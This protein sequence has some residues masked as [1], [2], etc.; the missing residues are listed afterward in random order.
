MCG[1]CRWCAC[2]FSAHTS[3]MLRSADVLSDDRIVAHL[4]QIERPAL[5]S[6]LERDGAT[7]LGE[8]GARLWQYTPTCALEPAMHAA[9]AH[10]LARVEASPD[11]SA[12]AL[13]ALARRRVLQTTPHVTLTDGPIFLAAHHLGSRGLAADEPYVV[14]ACSGIGF[15]NNAWP[16]CLSYG[17]LALDDL[18]DLKAAAATRWRRADAD[19]RR[20]SQE[21]RISLV[22][23]HGR[24]LVFGAQISEE[25]VACCEAL[26]GHARALV[27]VPEAGTSFTAWAVRVSAALVTRVLR[28]RVITLDLGAVIARYLHTVLG[29]LAHPLARLLFH[30]PVRTRVLQCLPPVPLFLTVG[31]DEATVLEPLRAE[32]ASLRG[33]T[34]T[35]PLE[36]E[37]I[38]EALA[39]EQLCPGTFLTFTA[40]IAQ[41]GFACFGGVD[42]LEYLAQFRPAWAAAGEWPSSTAPL[43]LLTSGRMVDD[44]G[45]DLFPLDVIYGVPFAP[46]HGDTLMGFLRPQFARLLQRPFAWGVA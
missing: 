40:L 33:R 21:R 6:L 30:A 24:E 17:R 25:T 23:R 20:D 35:L 9:F 27:G 31:A 22:P 32:G 11:D 36:P 5:A 43:D 4:R 37:V 19:R 44:H 10:E 16:G 38:R 8:W 26:V 18:V 15:A 29:D 45:V 13:V 14:G 12:A 28:R 46:V 41:N 39:A 42:Q 3:V 2:W 1:R 7:P 34:R